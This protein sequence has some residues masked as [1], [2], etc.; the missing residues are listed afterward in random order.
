[1][2]LKRFAFNLKFNFDV[3]T[4]FWALLPAV[5]INLHS[6]SFEIEWLCLAL[7][8]D[9]SVEKDQEDEEDCPVLYMVP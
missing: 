1:M 9:F 4:K 8:I 3:D 2:R 5:S 7:Y 6:H